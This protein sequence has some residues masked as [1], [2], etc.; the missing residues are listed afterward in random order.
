MT[1]IK[2]NSMY[3]IKIINQKKRIIR[4]F[5]KNKKLIK[6]LTTEGRVRGNIKSKNK[7]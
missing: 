3:L 1:V 6:S 7:K 5:I 2:K 4:I